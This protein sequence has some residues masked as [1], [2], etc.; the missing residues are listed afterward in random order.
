MTEIHHHPHHRRGA[1]RTGRSL[2][3]A[4]MPSV[5]A[6]AAVAALITSLAVWRG[7]TPSQP[8]AAAATTTSQAAAREALNQPTSSG[9][10]STAPVTTVPASTKAARGTT[11]AQEV[12]RDVE[13]VVL[14]QTSQAG[15]AGTVADVLRSKGW[16]VPAVG[17]FRGTV[18]ATTV[19]YPPGDEAAAQAAAESLPTA[20]RIRPT[21]GNLSTSR[22]TVVVTDTYPR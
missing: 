17:N 15:L 11:P 9:A 5:L 7:E 6:V 10:A 20:P 13:V 18:P 8:S 2:V 14:N 21:F 4:L 22:L 19:Y 1:H 3:H 16:T 12:G